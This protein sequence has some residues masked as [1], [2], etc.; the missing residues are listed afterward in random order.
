MSRIAN[1]Q[2]QHQEIISILEKIGNFKN[3]TDVSQNSSTLSLNI[4]FL[5]GK[6]MSH[7]QSEDK[8]L[9]P[10]LVNHQDHSIRATSTRFNK[11]MGDLAEQFVSF[12]TKYMVAKNIKDSPEEFLQESSKIF[13]AIRKRINAEEKE[14][15]PLLED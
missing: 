15:Y 3:L 9:Y 6:I 13:K 12:K 14:L 4:G 2:R 10:S 7:L 5:S 11:E 1:L 8:F